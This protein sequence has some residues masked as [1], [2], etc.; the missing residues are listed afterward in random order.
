MD[1]ESLSFFDLHRDTPSAIAENNEINLCELSSFKNYCACFAAFVRDDELHPFECAKKQ[2]NAFL[3]E[4][5]RQGSPCKAILTLENGIS[6]GEHTQR[7][8]FFAELGVK[9][10]NLTWNGENVLASGCMASGGLKTD[11]RKFIF[12]L[13]ELALATDLAHIN[14]QGF[15]EAVELAD[16]PFVSHTASSE[17]KLHPRNITLE[18]ARQ[19]ADKKGIIGLCFYPVFLPDNDIFEAIYSSLYFWCDKGLSNHISFGSDFEGADMASRLSSPLDALNLWEYLRSRGFD[20]YL[21][22]K[23]FWR[24]AADFFEI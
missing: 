4:Y 2:I 21:L 23:I 13:N 1:I 12:K 14:S 17:L 9:A 10:A 16:K 20:E 24:N 6:V 5:H 8:E 11:G 18:M 3:Q 19:I 15:F 7:L 22:E